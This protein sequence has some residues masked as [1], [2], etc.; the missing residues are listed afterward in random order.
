MG[1]EGGRYSHRL[2]T[3]SLCLESLRNRTSSN[4]KLHHISKNPSNIFF[5][6]KMGPLANGALCLSTPKHNDKSGTVSYVDSGILH[7][8]TLSGRFDHENDIFYVKCCSLF[9]FCLEPIS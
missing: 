2:S 6:R 7:R 5:G 8:G 9:I 4:L 3:L 1:P